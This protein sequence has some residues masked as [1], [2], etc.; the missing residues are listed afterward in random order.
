MFQRNCQV[1]ENVLTDAR[2]GHDL[3]MF[4]DDCNEWH[5]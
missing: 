4:N 5:G 2:Q 1:A 3:I